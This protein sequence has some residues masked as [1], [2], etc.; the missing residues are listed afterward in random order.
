[1]SAFNVERRGEGLYAVSGELTFDTVPAVWQET[2][3]WFTEGG[4]VVID[5]AGVN[6][7][8]SAGLALLLEWL[9]GAERR[10]ARV[11]FEH[12]P[13]QIQAMAHL[14]ALESVL[15]IGAAAG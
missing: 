14:T 15:E 11:A 9:R 10:D 4:A 1:M 5:L 7:A 8:D 3:D 2:R 6:R 13:V 12:L